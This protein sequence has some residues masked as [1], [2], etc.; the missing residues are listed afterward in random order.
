[1]STQYRPGTGAQTR[2]PREPPAERRDDA[3]GDRPSARHLRGTTVLWQSSDGGMADRDG[4]RP[5]WTCGEVMGL[6]A[7][8]HTSLSAPKYWKECRT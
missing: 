6:T 7:G 4:P 5:P 8:S 2:R 3:E 1:M